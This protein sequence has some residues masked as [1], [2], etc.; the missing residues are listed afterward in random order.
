MIQIVEEVLSQKDS[1]FEHYF[2]G[3][4]NGSSD[5]SDMFLLDCEGTDKSTLNRKSTDVV[6]GVSGRPSRPGVVNRS[7]RPQRA[8]SNSKEPTI[9]ESSIANANVP[10]PRVIPYAIAERR[11]DPD[12]AKVVRRLTRSGYQAYLVGGCV[13][14]LLLGRTPKDFDVATSAR[15]SE[16]KAI[17]R[18]CRIIGRRFRLAHILFGGSKIIEVAT[19]RRDPNLEI[20]GTEWDVD[21]QDEP[22]IRTRSTR[23][24]E[25]DLLIRQ[26]N[27][28]GDPHEDAARRDFTMNALFY[29][30]DRQ[31]IVDYVG[32]MAE[33]ERRVIRTIGDPDVRFREDPVRILRAIRFASRLDLGIEPDVYD[34]IIA[35][36]EELLR[37]ARPRLLEELLRLLRSGGSR[38]SIWLAW[39]TGVL[40]VLLPELSSFLDDDDKMQTRLWR[41]LDAIDAK[42]AG[43]SM[44][45]DP[46]L[47]ANLLFEPVE[48]ALENERDSLLAV[49]D[50][51]AD[52][53]ERL[54]IPRRLMDRMRSM[55]ALQKR[56]RAG[57][58]GSLMRR[59]FYPEA[60]MIHQLDA[61]A[62]E[63]RRSANV[64][65]QMPAEP[66][67]TTEVL[68]QS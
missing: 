53:V 61:A 51:L 40:A 23:R 27:A 60:L 54:A 1:A 56:F 67:E 36:R 41:R 15:P 55:L 52:A 12:A 21:Q 13:R 31:E 37:A 10:A 35:Q 9:D 46:V 58:V 64:V 42:I 65:S 29:D 4:K 28:F 68:P 25:E 43:G 11:I 34:A 7:D 50:Y 17:F 5:C 30:L 20:E 45:T 6:S 2:E 26:D 22:A 16:V 66:V 8:R 57:K 3:E 47:M 32:G 18:N 49:T 63:A 44:P 62:R 38:R 19:F 59:D 48:E 14:D 33:V 39:E 24:P